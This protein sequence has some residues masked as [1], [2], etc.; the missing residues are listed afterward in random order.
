MAMI[1]V[2]FMATLG[3]VAKEERHLSTQHMIFLTC[4]LTAVWYKA[5]CVW[6]HLLIIKPNILMLVAVMVTILCICTLKWGYIKCIICR[7]SVCW[8]TIK[9]R[10]GVH[11][12]LNTT[13]L[14]KSIILIL[15]LY[16]LHFLNTQNTNR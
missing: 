7:L 9:D 10:I 13:G 3:C 16:I 12:N 2:F 6:G 15:N 8:M 5:V 11:V 14:G 1:T 4:T